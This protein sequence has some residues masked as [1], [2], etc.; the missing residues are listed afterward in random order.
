MSDTELA[1]A[2]TVRLAPLDPEARKAALDLLGK[3]AALEPP[4]AM[5]KA[6]CLVRAGDELVAV[7]LRMPPG[8]L[9]WVRKALLGWPF[10]TTTYRSAGIKNNARTFGYLA[11]NTLL[12]RDGCRACQGSRLAPE[13]HHGIVAQAELLSAMLAEAAPELAAR[14]RA[15]AEAVSPE[16]R[17]G[18]SQWTSGVANSTSVLPYHFDRNNLEPV[19]SAMIVVR[20]GVRGGYLHVPELGAS[21]HCRDGDVVCFPGWR[22]VHG[23]TPVKIV[24][25]DGYRISA[26][27]Y[28]V[29]Q[30]RACG[31]GAEEMARA[32][33]A[34]TNREA[35]TRPT[36]DSIPAAI[37]RR[38]A[39]S[40]P[41]VE[42]DE[43]DEL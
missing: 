18:D 13:A 36:V 34:R 3:G 8:P 41:T 28:C 25:P 31:T 29:E 38:D 7:V 43:S 12:Q 26:V 42:D 30:M 6:P 2:V 40:K 4:G 1:P 16:W 23:V 5:I 11:R 35:D 15:A 17:M 21:F 9:A 39:A 27:Y 32:Q 14:D 20:R 37:A 19:W 22:F 24:E 33:L 10:D